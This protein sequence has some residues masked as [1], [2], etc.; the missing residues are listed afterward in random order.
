[1]LSDDERAT[2]VGAV[3][4]AVLAVAAALVV[5]LEGTHLRPGMT[6][7][8]ELARVGALQPGAKVRLAG[9]QLGDVEAIRLGPHAHA[10]LDL[11]IDRRHGR[12]LR[13][14]TDFFLMQE[15][16]LGETYVEIGARPGPRGPELEDGA[17][18][19]GVDPP[20]ID[21]LLVKSYKNLMATSALF[22][23][24][25]P[26]LQELHDAMADLDHTLAGLELPSG[27]AFA[28]LGAELAAARADFGPLAADARALG[29]SAAAASAALGPRIARLAATLSAVGARFDD[30]RLARL[31]AALD[32][33]GPVLAGL[34]RA[35]ASAEALASY[36]SGGQGT[37]GA[38]M[39]DVELSDEMKA[40]LRDLRQ[41]PWR[42]VTRPY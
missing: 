40:L 13:T 37:I 25:M 42:A 4:L 1:L 38:F 29:A 17:D 23:E 15:G 9:L 19:R 6:V 22:S 35:R 30:P 10:I 39:Q 7:H 24:G 26:E 14:T 34:E 8:V 16:V 5:G 28:R 32:E 2:R 3:T 21:E 12:L 27:A 41:H 20:P 36:V 11:W 33:V 18:V 31:G